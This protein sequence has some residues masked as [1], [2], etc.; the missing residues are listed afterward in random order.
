MQSQPLIS[1]QEPN[2]FRHVSRI[3]DPLGELRRELM[4][5]AEPV[6]ADRILAG[7]RDYEVDGPLKNILSMHHRRLWRAMILEHRSLMGTLRHE[8]QNDLHR[9]GVEADVAEDIDQSVMEELIDIILKRFR[10]SREMAKGF[11]L[12]LLSAASHMGAARAVA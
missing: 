7:Y 2:R 5:W 1:P 12:V 9:A 6:I 3:P 8:L 4:I 10:S 11:S